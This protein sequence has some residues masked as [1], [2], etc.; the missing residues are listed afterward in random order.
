MTAYTNG[1]S[2]ETHQGIRSRFQLGGGD[3]RILESNEQE[4]IPVSRTRHISKKTRKR[5]GWG[6]SEQMDQGSGGGEL[7]PR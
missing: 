6:K 4:N 5:G 3:P 7:D 2:R 1:P